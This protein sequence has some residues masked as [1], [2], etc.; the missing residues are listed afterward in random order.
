MENEMERNFYEQ[1]DAKIDNKK[2]SNS[3]LNGEKCESL[4]QEI[5]QLKERTKRLSIVKAL[6]C[7]S[8]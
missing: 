6:R 8:N 4:I 3:F 1:L 5:S 2:N 7:C